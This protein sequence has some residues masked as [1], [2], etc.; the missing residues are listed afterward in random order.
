MNIN[1]FRSV[2]PHKSNCSKLFTVKA[3]YFV[4]IVFCSF[5]HERY[6]IGIKFRGFVFVTLL[7]YTTKMCNTTKNV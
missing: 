3:L 5:P 4:G 7:Q 1:A 6:F 2:E